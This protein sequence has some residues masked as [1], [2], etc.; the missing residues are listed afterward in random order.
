MAAMPR[1][2]VRHE[3]ARRRRHVHLTRHEA[4]TLFFDLLR[5]QG[6][7]FAVDRDYQI[8]VDL[9]GLASPAPFDSSDE[10]RSVIDGLLAPMSDL[11]WARDQRAS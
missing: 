11:L 6:A 3:R 8:T 9:S 1:K 7:R 4:A 10:L 2:M 5:Q